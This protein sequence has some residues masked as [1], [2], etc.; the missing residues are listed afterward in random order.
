MSPGSR[1]FSYKPFG[2]DEVSTHIRPENPKR[3]IYIEGEQINEG[4]IEVGKNLGDFLAAARDANV[5]DWLWID[6]L[7]INQGDSTEKGQ[8]VRQMGQTYEHA[9]KVFVWLGELIDEPTIRALESMLGVIEE[10]PDVTSIVYLDKLYHLQEGW[11]RRLSDILSAKYWTRLWI[12]Q[13]FLLA[14]DPILFFG[15]F[16][17]G[18]H[19]LALFL[20]AIPKKGSFEVDCCE[21]F[22]LDGITVPEDRLE[23]LM[24]LPGWK[25][26]WW[27][28]V[29]YESMDRS[30][31]SERPMDQSVSLAS[32]IQAF[33]KSGCKDT[34]DRV[35]A[36]L[37][38][39]DDA[40]PELVDYTVGTDVVFRR[41]MAQ[42]RRHKR[43]L[44][45]L[46]LIGEALI[47][48]LELLPTTIPS[49]S[50][51]EINFDG[52]EHV[53]R[54]IWGYA[55]LET[56][57][58]DPEALHE[59]VQATCMYVGMRSGSDVHVFEYVVEEVEG[60]PIVKYCRTHE[61]L[62]GRSPACLGPLL[63]DDAEYFWLEGVPSESLNYFSNPGANC[64]G[65]RA[66]RARD[67]RFSG[68]MA[69]GQDPGHLI[70]PARR[71][72][73]S[74][75]SSES[76]AWEGWTRIR[77]S[78][79]FA[80][81]DKDLLLESMRY[82]RRVQHS[83]LAQHPR[84]TT[85]RWKPE[86]IYTRREIGGSGTELTRTGSMGEE[87]DSDGIDDN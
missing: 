31:P 21:H 80:T 13:E 59:M 4:A 55:T 32:L 6:A 22:T 8:Q 60:R 48:A 43:P 36:L 34:R 47:E 81:V 25:Y 84:S 10:A 24:H 33:T 17:T 62:R 5:T 85:I 58:K 83:A 38:F 70:L 40:D 78:S 16:Q 35:Y 66:W 50:T 12:A 86:E 75:R 79:V 14:D 73:D 46:L 74:E 64:H 30:R 27:R 57:D 65:L 87:S 77:T 2:H 20:G 49:S 11:I 76:V 39:A 15:N 9:K 67:F 82:Q 52:S 7:C 41:T 37:S 72:V 68:E 26:F 44:D 51:L 28:L 71:I 54:P 19:K 45:E 3:N 61:Y 42:M 63:Q 56:F 23:D 29:R 53:T 69:D 18:A 1:V